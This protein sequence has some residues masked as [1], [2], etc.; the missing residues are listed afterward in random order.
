MYWKNVRIYIP[1]VFFYNVI[2]LHE[3]LICRE[4]HK[5]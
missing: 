1:W 2:Y 3:Q 5:I 4:T